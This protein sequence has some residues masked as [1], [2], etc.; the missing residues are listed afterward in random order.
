[1]AGVEWT[2]LPLIGPLHLTQPRY[3]A[4]T[5]REIARALEPDAILLASHSP[6]GL[7]AGVW[8]DE[9]ELALWHLPP[10]A[11]R[12][13]VRVEAVGEDAEALRGEGER[14]REYLA[15][16]EKGQQYLAQEAEWRK[17][18]EALF[19]R[20]LTPADWGRPETL[21]A[22]GGYLEAVR[23][24]FGEGPAT[25]FRA[26]RMERVAERLAT[27]PEGRYLVLAELFDYPELLKRLP[28]A[29]P[30]PDHAPTEAE[31][32]RALLDRAW[33]LSEDDDFA[34]LLAQLQ[35][36]GTPEAAYLAAQVYLA[37][38]ETESALYLL[39]ETAKGD[40]HEPGYLPGYLLARLGQL[41]DL[42]GDREGAIRAYRGVL[43]LSWAPKEARDIARAGMKTP[44]RVG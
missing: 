31:R 33:Q 20:P 29:K 32:E 3:N 11:E 39:E 10:W 22:L 1:M 12:E 15:Q 21:E 30:P 44:F 35:G 36:I 38:G 14:F 4:V 26:L 42:V 43:A 25:G 23:R 8:R 16:T 27:L 41:R 37:A 18:V 13:G 6:E 7:S 34:Q 2:V 28:G 19:S 9:E 24:G 5:P 40:F 17:P